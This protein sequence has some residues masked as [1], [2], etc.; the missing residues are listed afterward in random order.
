MNYCR[1]C[2]TRSES[3][4]GAFLCGP[5]YAAFEFIKW[6]KIYVDLLMD[7]FYVFIPCYEIHMNG[8]P[9]LNCKLC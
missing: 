2:G 6:S 1:W 4:T 8:I 5:H 7:L 9:M 3:A